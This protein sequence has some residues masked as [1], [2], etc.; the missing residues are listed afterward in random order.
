MH[1]VVLGKV[2]PDYEVPSSD[3]ELVNNRA[4]ERY[5]RMIGLYDENAIELGVQIK[6]KFGAALT[7][8][9]YGTVDDIPVLRKGIAMG[10]EKLMIVLGVSN[11]PFIIASNLKLAIEKLGD[12]DL[13]LSGQQSADMDRGVVHSILAEMLNL[14]FIPQVSDVQVEN[15]VYKLNQI[16]ET[17][18]RTLEISGK[19]VLSITSVPENVPRIPAVRAIFAAKKKPVEKLEEID[20]VAMG[21]EEISVEIPKI[22][23]VCELLPAEDMDDTAR[24]L[25]QKL[26]EER[27]L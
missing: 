12:V 13:V 4:H 26:R 17:G 20:A 23:S 25:L 21:V 24:L 14:P 6:D 8:V 11:D 3:F 10:A 19:S 18:S 22:E 5:T 1:V 9:S 16:V 15:G 2:V 7:L 27:Y